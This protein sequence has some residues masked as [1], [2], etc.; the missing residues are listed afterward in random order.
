MAPNFSDQL[1]KRMNLLIAAGTIVATMCGT[2]AG[3]VT[4]KVT[5]EYRVAA[6]ESSIEDLGTDVETLGKERVDMIR[7]LARLESQL[8]SLSLKLDRIE[9]ILDRDKFGRS[10]SGGNK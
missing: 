2:V 1:L 7:T 3:V 8:T 6:L 4:F 5:A 9:G 10:L